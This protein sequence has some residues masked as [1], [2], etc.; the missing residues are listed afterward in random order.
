MRF[1]V[2]FTEL[3]AMPSGLCVDAVAKKPDTRDRIDLR[4]EPDLRERAERQAERF[5][6]GLSAYIRQAI[7]ERLERD[8]ASDPRES[9]D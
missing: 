7:T 2:H 9:E 5:G 3:S 1:G 4:C 6:Q 8:E